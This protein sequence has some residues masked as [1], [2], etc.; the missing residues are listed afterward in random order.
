MESLVFTAFTMG[1]PGGVHCAAMCGGIVGAVALRVERPG[2]RL[3]FSYNAGR[4]LSY[5]VA[6]ALVGT[7]GGIV[8]LVRIPG[9][10]D[11][12]REGFLCMYGGA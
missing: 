6:G 3:Q 1:L 9:L 2:I 4:I 10:A 5:A 12:I 8:G 7:F 11:A